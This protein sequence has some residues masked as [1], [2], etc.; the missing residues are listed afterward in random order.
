[1]NNTTINLL[2]QVN[3]VKNKYDD[4]AEYTGENFNIFNVLNVAY[5]ELSHSSIIAYLL[6]TKGQHRQK[7]VFLKLFIE[8]I[9]KLFDDESHLEKFETTNSYII[10]EKHVGNGRIDILVTNEKNNIIIENK[11]NA[12]DQSEQLKR[13]NNFDK[14]APIIYLTLNGKEPSNYSKSNLEIGKDFICVSY[15]AHIKNWLEKCIKEMANKP[16]IRE[17]LNQ[18][19]HL[20]KQLTNQASNNNMAQE[21]TD[22]VM[23]DEES[24][25]SYLSLIQIQSKVIKEIIEKDFISIIEEIAQLNNLELNVDSELFYGKIYKGFSIYHQELRNKNLKIRFHFEGSNYK[26]ALLGLNYI[27][28]T[29]ASDFD[30]TKIIEDFEKTFEEA[31]TTSGN[32]AC[33]LWYQKMNDLGNFNKLKELRFGTLKEEL[34]EDWSYKISEMLKIVH[35]S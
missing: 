14:N 6:N 5:N 35:N 3:L 21:I 2:A 9:K 11:I 1:M 28:N 29:K 34:K 7:D 19:L 27:D 26:S 33:Y 12:G 25:N 32:F 10:K 8:E 22:R 13:Y 17:T 16:I 30:Y 31:F 15:E 18:Y 24:F 20:V 23:K 4:L